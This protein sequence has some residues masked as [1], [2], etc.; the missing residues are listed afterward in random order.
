MSCLRN[1]WARSDFDSRH[2][3]EENVL[4]VIG[5][6]ILERVL[7]SEIRRNAVGIKLLVFRQICE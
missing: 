5:W 1:T 7:V 3:Y 4:A 6:L 2:H